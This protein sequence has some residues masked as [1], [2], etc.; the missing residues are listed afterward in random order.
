MANNTGGAGG[1][2]SGLDLTSSLGGGANFLGGAPDHSY[3][4]DTLDFAGLIFGGQN[5]ILNYFVNKHNRDAATRAKD[6]ANAANEARYQQMLGINAYSQDLAHNQLNKTGQVYANRVK[7]LGTGYDRAGA[8]LTN[9]GN[10]QRQSL[11]DRE[12]GTQGS[13][14]QSLQSRGLGGTTLLPGAQRAV[15]SDTNR[16]LNDLSSQVGNA[17]SSL[18]VGRANAIAGAQGDLGRFM[19]GRTGFETGLL[20][21]RSDIIGSKQDQLNSQIL[22]QLLAA[23]GS[24]AQGGNLVTGGDLF[25]GA[26]G[27]VG[28]IFGGI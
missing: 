23:K 22:A 16:S 3:G 10:A 26:S 15:V 2:F 20:K 1:A 17:R 28:G 6:A 24:A 5:P 25:S 14:L 4:N 12:T 13:I 11:L 8:E 9:A 18:Q 27:I 21:E 19:T 7:D